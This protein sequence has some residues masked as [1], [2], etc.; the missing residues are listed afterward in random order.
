VSRKGARAAVATGVADDRGGQDAPIVRS[1]AV[2]GRCG[3]YLVL[4]ELHEVVGGGN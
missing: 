2:S 3:G 1:G 4:V